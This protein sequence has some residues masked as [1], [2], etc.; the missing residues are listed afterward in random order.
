M[1]L[2]YFGLFLN[3]EITLRLLLMKKKIS[4]IS[5][6]DVCEEMFWFISILLITLGTNNILYLRGKKIWV[7]ESLYLDF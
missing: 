6:F 3:L 5:V 1:D 2:S 4:I 7:G